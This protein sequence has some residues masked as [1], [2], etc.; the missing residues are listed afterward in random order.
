[1]NSFRVSDFFRVGQ[2]LVRLLKFRMTVLRQANTVEE[3]CN[4][5]FSTWSDPEHVNRTGLTLALNEASKERPFV[6]ETGTSAYGTDSTRLFDRFVSKYS[7]KFHSVD[8]NAR[9]ARAL[10][11]QLGPSTTL[12][13]SDSVNFIESRLD[14]LTNRIDLCYL[15]S[16]DVD[17]SDPLPSAEHGLNEFIA[18]MKFLKKDSILIIDDTPSSIK[19]IPNE[20]LDSSHEF[21]EKHGVLPGK[22]SLALKLIKEKKIG[23]VL[24]HEYNVVI[25][26]N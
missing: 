12:H 15:D 4:I 1:M 6:F 3:I 16:W 24:L 21:F 9:A 2:F 10:I 17:W 14:K 11:F 7:G 13:T 25:K 18:V 26:I 23:E 19:Y 5:H 22:G 20:F 8:L